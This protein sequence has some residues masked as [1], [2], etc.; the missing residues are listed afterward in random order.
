[1]GVVSTNLKRPVS[2]E[3]I[4]PCEK[5]TCYTDGDGDVQAHVSFC[6]V[7]ETDTRMN[8]D[9]KICFYFFEHF[10]FFIII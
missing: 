1:M 6:M 3:T 7:L 4:V 10:S 8:S 9:V 2:E 5:E